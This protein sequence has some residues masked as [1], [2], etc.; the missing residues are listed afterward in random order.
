M[1][2]HFNSFLN[3]ATSEHFNENLHKLSCENF[4]YDLNQSINIC[5]Q[6]SDKIHQGGAEEEYWF[7]V[8]EELYFLNHK[9]KEQITEEK[10][11]LFLD[12]MDR[13]S[14]NIRELLEK[15]CSYV[16]IQAIINVNFNYLLF[17]SV[18]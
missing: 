16:S 1:N 15:M 14:L 7:I 18:S 11:Q 8:L 5:E 12:F 10:K 17:I 2:E 9:L 3:N 13:I 6:N 4:N